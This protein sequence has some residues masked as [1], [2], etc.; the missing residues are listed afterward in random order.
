MCIRDRLCSI[1]GVEM[2]WFTFNEFTYEGNTLLLKL[3]V[4]LFAT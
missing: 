3:L 2:A 1:W 4:F